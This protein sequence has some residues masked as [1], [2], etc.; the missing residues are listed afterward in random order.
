MN[1]FIDMQIF[2][3]CSFYYIFTNINILNVC[4]FDTLNKVSTKQTFSLLN[5]FVDEKDTF[6]IQTVSISA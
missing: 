6:P 4:L 2:S 3:E 1:Q 5:F